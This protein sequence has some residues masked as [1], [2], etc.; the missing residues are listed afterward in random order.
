MLG[1]SHMTFYFEEAL[2]QAFS[3]HNLALVKLCCFHQIHF[4]SNISHPLTAATD[5]QCYSP[6]SGFNDM[7]DRCSYHLPILILVT[8][9]KRA[10]LDV[11]PVLRMGTAFMYSCI[12]QTDFFSYCILS[13]FRMLN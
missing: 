6:G 1:T 4:L 9:L 11:P 13:L 2:S 10:F 8:F 3:H 5:N 7:A 12:V